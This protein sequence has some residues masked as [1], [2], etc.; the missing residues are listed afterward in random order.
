MSDREI[1]A[2]II[3]LARNGKV[4]HD[5]LKDRT[6]EEY[7][8]RPAPSK[9]NL[10]EIVCHLHDEEIKDFRTRIQHI[11]FNIQTPMV[12]IDPEGWVVQNKYGERDFVVMLDSF[13][14]ERNKSV[15]WLESLENPDWEN[16]MQHPKIG[17]VSAGMLISNWLAHDYLHIRQINR[18][19]YEMLQQNTR[20]NLKYAGDW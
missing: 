8:W 5:L 1:K 9:W 10:L 6:Q 14:D 19:C 13:M 12:P 7:Y 18:Y 15:L 2:I 11:L 20:Q 16:K 17:T 4:F 3:G